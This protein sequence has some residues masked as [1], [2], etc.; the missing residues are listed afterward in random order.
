MQVS[1]GTV[2]KGKKEK[3]RILLLAVAED[4]GYVI[5]LLINFPW[6]PGERKSIG[7]VLELHLLTALFASL[8]AVP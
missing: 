5:N 6:K 3:R 8:F 2:V 7:S 1:V 4:D